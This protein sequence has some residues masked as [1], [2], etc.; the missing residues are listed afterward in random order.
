MLKMKIGKKFLLTI[1]AI[2]ILSSLV[3]IPFDNIPVNAS[4]S[5]KD[6]LHQSITSAFDHYLAARQIKVNNSF[7]EDQFQAFLHDNPRYV[8]ILG[9]Y[10]N[11][12]EQENFEKFLEIMPDI[13]GATAINEG[14]IYKT[15]TRTINGSN[16]IANL[17]NVTL[18]N[19]VN[20][21]KI[22]FCTKGIDPNVYVMRVQNTLPYW[23]VDLP[24][25][26]SDYMGVYIAPGQETT[27]WLNQV[28]DWADNHND[29]NEVETA[30]FGIVCGIEIPP[31]K[32]FSIAGGIVG[33]ATGHY[34]G[35]GFDAVRDAM[36]DT[37]ANHP[38]WGLNW[39]LENTYQYYPNGAG[40]TYTGYQRYYV[41]DWSL[42]DYPFVFV[43]GV[44]IDFHDFWLYGHVINAMAIDDAIDTFGDYWGWNQW[45]QIA[46]DQM[47]KILDPPAPVTVSVVGVD[48]YTGRNLYYESWELVPVYIDGN[49]VGNLGYSNIVTTPVEPGDHTITVGNSYIYAYDESGYWYATYSY[50]DFIGHTD[51]NNPS[52]FSVLDP[53]SIVIHYY[54]GNYAYY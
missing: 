30:I 38:T 33:W 9:R 4:I 40:Y 37:D 25:G 13:A 10:L 17:R 26:F 24:C 12:T 52:P 54:G 43:P 42:P 31:G 39:C 1:C 34:A 53:I 6:R 29:I 23:G 11:L 7:P 28:N 49:L 48:D 15:T 3:L 18:S 5:T 36:V 16:V 27:Q 45:H 51:T 35:S 32:L 21:T 2:A 46:Y 44:T 19:G 41:R 22:T 20:I 8:D 47:P 14:P 50:M